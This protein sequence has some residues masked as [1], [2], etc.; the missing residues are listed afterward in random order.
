MQAR[1]G[2]DAREDSNDKHVLSDAGSVGDNDVNNVN[3][4]YCADLIKVFKDCIEGLDGGGRCQL[5]QASHSRYKDRSTVIT[6]HY[7]LHY[8]DRLHQYIKSFLMRHYQFWYITLHYTLVT[9]MGKT[10]L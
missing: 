7:I 3:P 8:K 5:P 1:I 4:S 10:T 9:R 6:L 2:I